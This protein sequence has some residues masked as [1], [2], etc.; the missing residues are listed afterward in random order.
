MWE[1][2]FYYSKS[3]RRIIII[4]LILVAVLTAANIGY[5][6]YEKEQLPKEISTTEEAEIHHFIS[7]LQ[8]ET[9]RKHPYHSKKGSIQGN[10]GKGNTGA[11]PLN[12]FTFD[13]NKADSATLAQLGLSS[14]VTNNIIKYRSKGGIFRNAESLKKIYGMDETTYHQLKPYIVIGTE[15]APRQHKA[16]TARYEKKAKYAP[17][18]T[19]SI[20]AAD[21]VALQKIPGIGTVLSKRIVDYRNRLGGFVSESQLL[22]VYGI[23]TTLCQWITI[24]S[25]LI[26]RL[27]VNTS[28]LEVLKEHPYI[29]YYK[30]KEIL[31]YRQRYGK[32]KSIATLS[33]LEGFTDQDIEKLKPYLTF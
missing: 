12:P 4:L 33:M 22:E 6:W 27:N 30:A 8:K 20:N 11:L 26:K 21:T 29:R 5:N 23:D 31:K 9:K 1:D 19:I 28:T 16:P 2:F 10:T 17:G 32:I 25:M 15:Y 7:Q 3:E 13:P 24:D 18:T 14:Y